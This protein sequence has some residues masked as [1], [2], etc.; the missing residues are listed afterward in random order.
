MSSLL[1]PHN[2]DTAS[3]LH[4]SNRELHELAANLKAWPNLSE[5]GPSS[6][7]RARTMSVARSSPSSVAA[8]CR[9][10]LTDTRATIVKVIAPPRSPAISYIWTRA[11]SSCCTLVLKQYGRAGDLNA[12]SPYMACRALILM[13]AGTELDPGMPCKCGGSALIVYQS[14]VSLVPA[15][16]KFFFEGSTDLSIASNPRPQSS[17]LGISSSFLSSSEGS[18]SSVGPP[19]SLEPCSLSP[20]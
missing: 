19:S 16:F 12:S 14:S 11:A 17:G 13:T 20:D 1:F 15:F 7:L 9:G 18:F 8:Y 4:F 3:F 6:S 5:T 10:C 2:F